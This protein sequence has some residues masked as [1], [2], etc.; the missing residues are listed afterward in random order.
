MPPNVAPTPMPAFAPVV[1]PSDGGEGVD[2]PVLAA[3]PVTV[4]VGDDAVEADPDPDTLPVETAP[5]TDDTTLHAPPPVGEGGGGLGL[6][7]KGGTRVR[8]PV[9]VTGGGGGG[10]LMSIG[11]VMDGKPIGEDKTNDAVATLPGIEMADCRAAR[12]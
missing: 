1:R 6:D 2:V 10:E 5:G 9:F 3:E 7:T 11:G 4:P 12:R 8:I